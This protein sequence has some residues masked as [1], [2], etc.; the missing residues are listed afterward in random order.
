[1][2]ENRARKNEFSKFEPFEKLEIQGFLTDEMTTTDNYFES[3]PL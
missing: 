2:Q 3:A 1:M